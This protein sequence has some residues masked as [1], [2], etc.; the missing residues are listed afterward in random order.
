MPS[1]E[2]R[3]VPPRFDCLLCDDRFLTD[4]ELVGHLSETHTPRDVL[5]AMLPINVGGGVTD[6]VDVDMDISE[7]VSAGAC[8]VCDHEA[9]TDTGKNLFRALQRHVKAAHSTVEVYETL[10]SL[11][12]ADYE[13]SPTYDD[14][15][16]ADAAGT[17]MELVPDDI[18]EL[19]AE[20]W[21]QSVSTGR[22]QRGRIA[23]DDTW[24]AVAIVTGVDDPR[25]D[26]LAPA[27]STRD[28]E[29]RAKTDLADEPVYMQLMPK[30]DGSVSLSMEALVKQETAARQHGRRGGGMVQADAL[31]GAR[32]PWYDRDYT[33]PWDEPGEGADPPSDGDEVASPGGSR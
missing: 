18:V 27:W 29:L 13:E 7:A 12:P 22:F 24:T 31:E 21:S 28:V 20:G 14:G 8:P 16:L 23:D 17:V 6:D 32:T 25:D 15:G 11:Y 3:D 2:P 9:E 19:H 33:T 1:E 26:P 10:V 4:E 5:T 30:Q